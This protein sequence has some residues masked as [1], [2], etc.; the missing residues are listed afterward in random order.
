MWE[1][2][3]QDY[4]YFS[5]CISRPSKMEPIG[6]PETS[7]R[8]YRCTLRNDPEERRSV[9]S[10][11]FKCPFLADVIQ[12]MRHVFLAAMINFH[13]LIWADTVVASVSEELRIFG[14]R[15][16]A[17]DNWPDALR[18][19]TWNTGSNLRNGDSVPLTA[20]CPDRPPHT[21]TVVGKVELR[22]CV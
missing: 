3:L 22:Q 19:G 17:S 14:I 6:C 13:C 21:C 18:P 12:L 4:I 11:C 2:C 9:L 20:I 1:G 15:I 8:I 16:L 7:V 5:S 10:V